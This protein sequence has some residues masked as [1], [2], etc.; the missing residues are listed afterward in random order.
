MSKIEAKQLS[1]TRKERSQK[2]H[3]KERR[4]KSTDG[5][6]FCFLDKLNNN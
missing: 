4:E 6:S 2:L 5:E 3:D 1:P